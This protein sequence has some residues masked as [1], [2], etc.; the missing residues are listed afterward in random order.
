[1]GRRQLLV[2]GLPLASGA[3]VAGIAFGYWTRYRISALLATP[4]RPSPFDIAFD[5]KALI[6][7]IG[8]AYFTGVLFSLA[9]MWHRGVWR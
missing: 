8:M 9:P 3:G 1:M 2:E 7:S 4:W 6:V 5:P